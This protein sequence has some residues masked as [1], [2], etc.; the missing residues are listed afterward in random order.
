MRQ[1]HSKYRAGS[2]E[3]SLSLPLSPSP[4]SRNQPLDYSFPQPALMFAVKSFGT[5]S[6][7]RNA[8]VECEA[9]RP[10]AEAASEDAG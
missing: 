4:P 5:P 6:R 7:C 8:R 3:H 10:W 2:T 1:N 9:R